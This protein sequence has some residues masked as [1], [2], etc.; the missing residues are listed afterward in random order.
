MYGR[1][2]AWNALLSTRDRYL[3]DVS[4][5][6]A[7]DRERSVFSPAFLETVA[8]ASDPREQFQNYYDHAPASDT[9]S[10]LM[11]LDLKTYLAGDILAKVD[12]M[13]MATSLEVRV[14]ILDHVFVE[15]AATMPVEWKFRD[16][17]RKYLLKKLAQRLGIPPDLLH[18]R[19]QG[20]QLP[21]VEWMRNELKEQFLALLLEPQTL[22]RGYFR[23][24]AVRSLVKEHVSKRRNRSGILWRMLI[25]ELWHRNFLAGQ[26]IGCGRVRNL[27]AWAFQNSVRSRGLLRKRGASPPFMP[28]VTHNSASSTVS[29]SSRSTAPVFVVGCPRSGTTYLY[30]VLLSAG[31]FAVYRAESEVFHLLE[32]AFGDLSVAGK[33]KNSSDRMV[34]EPSITATGLQRRA[35]RRAH[36]ARMPQRRRLSAH[37]DAANGPASGR[38]TLGGLHA[39]SH[40]V[41]SPHQADH[42]RRAGNSHHPGRAR[43]GLVDGK[44]RM[45]QSNFHGTP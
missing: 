43:R 5:L 41:S 10:R 8:D 6:P 34:P 39:R 7:L 29:P 32:P 24:E 22:Q 31:N 12:R 3:D 11:Y 38:P 17:T 13:S 40:P 2:R 18:R 16:G 23:P 42:S 25:L 26:R 1:N 9:L 20:F 37:C 4:Y 14:P 28:D 19:K 44:T 15:W 35:P 27:P 36:P 45:A 33:P 30:H 21:L